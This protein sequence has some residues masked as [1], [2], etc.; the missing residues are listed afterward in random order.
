M[1]HI[2][3]FAKANYLRGNREYRKEIKALWPGMV[4]LVVAGFSAAYS[5]PCEGS[6]QPGSSWMVISG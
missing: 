1:R 2:P 4:T 3:A 5:Q 6:E